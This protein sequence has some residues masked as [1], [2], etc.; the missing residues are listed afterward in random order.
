MDLKLIFLIILGVVSVIYLTTLFFKENVF[1]FVLKGLLIP[2]ILAVYIFGANKVFLPI[3]LALIFAWIGDVLLIKISNLL[4]FR[5]GLASFLIG[6]ICYIT[7]MFG[8]G[9][10][11]NI[12][13]LIICFIVGAG[14]GFLIFKI[15]QPTPDMKIPV[16]AYETIILVMAIFAVQLFTSQGGGFGA[17][18]L[19]GSICFVASDTSLA[20][21]TFRKK[22]YYVFVMVTYIAAQLLITLGF[23]SAVF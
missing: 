11:F 14:L 19:A 15:I 8:F 6:H 22:P 3:V 1:Q 17:L 2:L 18:V 7:A 12:P 20:L 13:F 5:L 9:Q 21:V 10:P 16:I 4:C 23:C